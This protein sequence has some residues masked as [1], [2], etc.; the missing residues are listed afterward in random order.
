MERMQEYLDTENVPDLTPEEIQEIEGAGAQ[1]HRRFFV[2]CWRDRNV[3]V[4]IHLQSLGFGRPNNSVVYFKI[5]EKSDCHIN[6]QHIRKYVH[7]SP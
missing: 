7:T 6:T 3:T 2:S 4:N 5:A 1:L